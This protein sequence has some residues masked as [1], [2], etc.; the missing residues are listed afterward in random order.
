MKGFLVGEVEFVDPLS[1]D[2]CLGTYYTVQKYNE[3]PFHRAYPNLSNRQ[4]DIFSR[5]NKREMG[6]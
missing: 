4:K 3:Y 1:R 6:F 2:E 5:R